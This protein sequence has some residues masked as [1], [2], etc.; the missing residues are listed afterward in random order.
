MGR[1]CGEFIFYFLFLV[2]KD[3]GL[4]FRLSTLGVACYQHKNRVLRGP[5]KSK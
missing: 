1:K 2:E 3:L 4:I 5:M